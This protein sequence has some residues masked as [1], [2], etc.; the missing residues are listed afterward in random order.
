MSDLPVGH[1]SLSL[2]LAKSELEL[3]LFR[4]MERSRTAYYYDW[5]IDRSPVVHLRYDESGPRLAKTAA[6][7]AAVGTIE[8]VYCQWRQGAP[9]T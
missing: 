3:W 9:D 5:H 1:F 4:F 2:A 6:A 8:K 7:S